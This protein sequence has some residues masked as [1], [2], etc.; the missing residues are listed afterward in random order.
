MSQVPDLQTIQANPEFIS[1][2]SENV[3]NYFQKREMNYVLPKDWAVLERLLEW[4]S[5]Q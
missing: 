3:K 4:V 5:F 1:V 2:F